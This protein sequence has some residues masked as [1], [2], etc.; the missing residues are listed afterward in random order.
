MRKR[1][2][3][4]EF[5]SGGGLSVQSSNLLT[6][7]EM[8]LQAV[9]KQA[10]SHADQYEIAIL[11]DPSLPPVA[12]KIL[13]TWLHALAW[14]EIFL[15]IAPET[16]QCLQ[17]LHQQVIAAGKQWWG[18]GT[19]AIQICSN[20]AHTASQLAKHHIP[21]I[22][23]CAPTELEIKKQYVL[24]PIDGAGCDETFLVDHT[25][26][27]KFLPRIQ[28]PL[29]QPYIQGQACSITVLYHQHAC[30]VVAVNTQFIKIHQACFQYTGMRVNSLSHALKPAQK[31]AEKIHHAIPQL[32]GWVGIDILINPIGEWIVVE[33]N[34]RLTTAYV[35]LQ[36]SLT[37]NPFTL[38]ELAHHGKDFIEIPLTSY[39][40]DIYL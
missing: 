30:R 4:Y 31:L 28:H 9:L 17:Q 27:E 36:Q 12:V 3:I 34:P 24:K 29:C 19:T 14:G 5:I 25:T 33:I 22:P 16:A 1:L 37:Y 8:M 6:E 18:C 13:P 26:V 7:G 2:V 20:K 40:I 39:P 38:L 32:W 15:V 21:H 11:R 35:G 23:C 10:Q